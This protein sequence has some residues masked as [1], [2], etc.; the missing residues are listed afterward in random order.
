VAD[1]AWICQ[2]VEHGLVRPSLVPPKPI[3]RLRDLTRYRKALIHERTRET[4]RLT[5]PGGCQ[6]GCLG[7]VERNLHLVF[8]LFKR[9]GPAAASPRRTRSN[10]QLGS[11][12]AGRDG[13]L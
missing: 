9:S 8:P 3:R 5:V 7:A 4:Q 2:L 6:A 13:M 10:A 1:A 12:A 11:D